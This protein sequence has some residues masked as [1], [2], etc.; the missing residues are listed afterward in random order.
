VSTDPTYEGRK[1]EDREE[2]IR[3]AEAENAVQESAEPEL[4][5]EQGGD[6]DADPSTRR[7]I[8]PRMGARFVTFGLAGLVAG[9]LVGLLLVALDAD[10]G[11]PVGT[12]V[13][14]AL[15]VGLVTA[16]LGIF[17][18]LAREDGRIDRSTQRVVRRRSRRQAGGR[19]G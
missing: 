14:I 11:G 3:R 10:P 15:A 1:V 18:L 13:M 7:Q 9:A 17:P 2:T 19:S 12:V 4:Y 8:A 16:V 6:P 5:A